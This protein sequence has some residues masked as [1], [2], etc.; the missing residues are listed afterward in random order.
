MP[1]LSGIS[2]RSGKKRPP[3]AAPAPSR[4]PLHPPGDSGGAHTGFLADPAA[5]LEGLGAGAVGVWRWQVDS[6]RLDWTRNLEAV[7]DLP[8]GSFDGTL[9]SFQRDIHPGDAARVWARISRSLENGDAYRVVYRTRPKPDGSFVWVEA[10]GGLVQGPDGRRFLTGVCMDVSA[11]VRAE[12][13]LQRRLRQQQ[14]VERFGSFAFGEPQLQVILDRAV[15]TAADVLG[16]PLAAIYEI[17]ASA[18]RLRLRAGTGW[19]EGEVGETTV[20]A[21]PNSQAGY[22]LMHDR[23]VVVADL[24]RESRF[25]RSVL[26]D[27]HGVR[28]GMTVVIPGTDRRPFGVFGVHAREPRDFDQADIDFLLAL[29]NIVANS[30]RHVA[31]AEHRHLLVREMAHRAGNMLQLV[32]TIANQTFTGTAEPRLARAAF[33]ERLASLSRANY[34]VARGGWTST[35]FADL[36]GEVLKP[37]VDRLDISGLDI[38]LPP[39]LCFDMGLV[40]HELAT[41]SVKYGSLGEPRGRA[42]LAWEIRDGGPAGEVFHIAWLDPRGGGEARSAKGFGSRLFTALVER[43]WNGT[44]EVSRDGG[45]RF[46]CAIPLPRE[47]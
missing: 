40:L 13:E 26:L 9:A 46:A 22:T 25:P 31:A 43:K 44:I 41:N 39:E 33:G 23:P 29:A 6:D 14:A 27:R 8:A 4:A 32:V 5:L 28:A 17:G 7:H 10:S 1:T 42:S 45:Y 36:A 20:N 38:L 19:A 2:D 11:R 34:L 37:F 15:E 21:G 12:A 47:G 30:V 16:L 3:A 24:D 35:R 18:D